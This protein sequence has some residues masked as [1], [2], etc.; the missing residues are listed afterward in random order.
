MHAGF[1]SLP[2]QTMRVWGGGFKRLWSEGNPGMK[3]ETAF[4]PYPIEGNGPHDSV[5]FFLQEPYFV[6]SGTCYKR[7]VDLVVAASKLFP[8]TRILYRVHPESSLDSETKKRFAAL[9]NLH[10][11]SARR[12]ESV[13]AS[14]RVVVSHFSSAIME[15]IVHGCTPLVFNPTPGWDFK[16]DLEME[17]IGFVSHN[18]TEFFAKLEKALKFLISPDKQFE[19][20]S[21]EAPG[22]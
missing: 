6:S 5:A 11:V 17:K 9:P 12:L 19:W 16:P 15:C 2:F 10:D 8:D 20:F 21:T 4:Y 14:T 7:F 3:L 18:E 22:L 13:Y 1:T